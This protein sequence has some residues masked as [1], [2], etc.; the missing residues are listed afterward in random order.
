MPA[1]TETDSVPGISKIAIDRVSCSGFNGEA[2]DQ[3][4]SYFGLM[5]GVERS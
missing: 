1:R 5:P 4:M 3:V 2:S